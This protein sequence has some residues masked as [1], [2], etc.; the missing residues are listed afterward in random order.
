MNKPTFHTFSNDVLGKRD[1]VA[2]QEMLWAGKISSVELTQAALKRLEKAQALTSAVLICGDE[3]LKHAKDWDAKRKTYA[4][5]RGFGGI[6]SLLKDN[7]DL[8]G[9]PTRHGSRATPS[10]PVKKSSALVGQFHQIGLHFLGKTKLPE[11]GFTATT[12]FTQGEPARNPWNLDH[13]TGGSSGGSAALVAAGVVPIAHANDGGGSIRIPASAC[14]L[15]GLKPSRG[16]LVPNEMAKSL[17]VKIVSDGVV[18]RSVRDTAMFYA[19]A[20][21]VFKNP[22]L[23]AIG[24]VNSPLNKRLR[25]GFF[26]DKA[27]GGKVHPDCV[28]G[29]LQTAQLLE[30]LGHHVEEIPLP[31]NEQFAEDFLMYWAFMAASV[32]YTGKLL[33]GRAWNSSQME[34]FSQH[35]ADHLTRRIHR[36]P[37]TLRRLKQFE[38]EYSK[39]FKQYDILLSATLG[40][41]PPVIGHLALDLPF[42]IA[43]ERLFDFACYTAAQNVSGAPAISLPLHFSN[44]LPVGIHFASATGQEKLLLELALQL[45]ESTNNF[46]PT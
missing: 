9:F 11:F 10:Q 42:P 6:P 2:L 8:A 29:V 23:P 20:E 1:A 39:F 7:M 36:L 16:R 24:L 18:T 31:V 38:G 43:Q 44:G 41:P 37:M 19:E 46:T 30:S 12:E 4:S 14:G 45:E 40:T 13:S 15:V 28:A 35:L 17:P 26:T 32:K 3:A 27:T 25:I 22:K 21:K 33:F 34:P 5:H